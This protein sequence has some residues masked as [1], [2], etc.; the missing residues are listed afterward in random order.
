MKRLIAAIFLVQSLSVSADE[1]KFEC[2][3]TGASV[4]DPQRSETYAGMPFQ[5]G[6][7]AKYELKYGLLRVLVGYGF[8]RVMPPEKQPVIVVSKDGKPVEEK[9]WQRI[10]QSEAFT[11]DWYKMIFAAHDKIL[12]VSR[13]WDYGITKFYIKQNEEKPFVRRYKIEKWLDFDHVRCKVS[14]RS[15]DE[16]KNREET[17]EFDFKPTSVDALGAL[18]RLRTFD[19]KK[20]KQVRVPIYTSE[21]NWWMEANVEGYETITVNAGTFP[22]AKISLK[23][24]IGKDLQQRGKLTLWMATDHP[25]RPMVKIEGE[26]TF[27]SIYLSLERLTPG[28]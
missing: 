2:P 18:Y 20:D 14:E 15:K 28:P 10:F 6:E 7:E 9:R 3:P 19:F 26:V 5:P 21:K 12:A 1:N 16:Q 24:F 17:K 8:M 4:P 13:P 23:T 11:G 25:N 22:C 27:G